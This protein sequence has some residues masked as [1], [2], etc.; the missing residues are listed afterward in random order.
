MAADQEP[1]GTRAGAGRWALGA[2]PVTGGASA[3]VEPAFRLVTCGLV[4]LWLF[5]F[6]SSPAPQRIVS[7]IPAVTEMLFAIGAGPQVV[8]VSS[9]DRHPPGVAKLARVGGLVDPDVERILALRPD[10]VIVYQ[11]QAD[12]RTQLARARIPTFDYAHGSLADVTSTIRALGARTGHAAEADAVARAI[13]RDL[14]AVRRRVAGRR[15]PRTLVVFGRD[16]L[17]LRGIFASG[18]AGFLHDLVELAGGLNVFGD[19]R[20]QSVQ[21]T[22]EMILAAEPEVL[23]ELRAGDDLTPEA[24]ERERRVWQALSAVPAVQHGR[25]WFLVGLE[26]VVPGPRVMTAAD[27]FARALHPEVY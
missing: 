13:E 10:L 19:V 7:I 24:I 27:R 4:G 26:L 8:G 11:S 6:Q 18:G 3:A 17:A 9:F 25:V 21:A 22:T 23:L 16:P 15:R 5:T 14:D 20:R 12:L 1:V 2:G